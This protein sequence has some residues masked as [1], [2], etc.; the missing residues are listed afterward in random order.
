MRG[1]NVGLGQEMYQLL[2]RQ[3]H[4]LTGTPSARHLQIAQPIWGIYF[5]TLLKN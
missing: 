3:L 2:P 4:F 5:K 1:E